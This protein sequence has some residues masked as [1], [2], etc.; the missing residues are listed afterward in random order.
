ME[1]GSHSHDLSWYVSAKRLVLE[2]S[3]DK[4]RGLL[5]Q[6]AWANNFSSKSSVQMSQ[7]ENFMIS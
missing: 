1:M 7:H 6:A 5:L 2:G 3:D 4:K